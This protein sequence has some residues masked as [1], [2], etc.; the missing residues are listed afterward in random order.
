MDVS[1]QKVVVIG[2]GASGI[3]AARL[4]AR[5]GADVTL[6]DLR[7]RAELTGAAK[8]ERA[9]VRLALGDHDP[10]IFADAELVVVSPGVPPLDI[11]ATVEA[12]SLIHI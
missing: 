12:L 7:T 4:L 6:N 3:A 11:F 1:N 8:L 5:K 9:G 10:S 2:G